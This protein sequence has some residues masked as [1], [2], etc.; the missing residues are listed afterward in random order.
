[1]KLMMLEW[2]LWLC[3]RYL[4]RCMLFLVKL[5]IIVCCRYML[6]FIQV[7]YRCSIS[8]CC[9][10]NSSR[11]LVN[12]KIISLLLRQGNRFRFWY[13]NNSRQNVEVQVKN[14]M[15]K[16]RWL[17]KIL[18]EQMFSV[19]NMIIVSVLKNSSSLSMLLCSFMGIRLGQYSRNSVGVMVVSVCISLVVIRKYL[20]NLVCVSDRLFI[21]FECMLFVLLIMGSLLSGQGRVR[22]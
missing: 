20:M 19:W 5:R 6:C 14:M 7:W 9:M 21:D 22:W 4:V 18:L 17:L 8:R 1:M 13:M 12:Q 16:C 11:L 15:W 2:M 3:I 10:L